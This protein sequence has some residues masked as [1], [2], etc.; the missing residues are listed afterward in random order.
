M[1]AAVGNH[2]HSFLTDG[3]TVF[4]NPDVVTD[5]LWVSAFAVKVNKGPDIPVF[6]QPV[7][8]K[9]VHGGIKAHVPDAQGRHILFQFVKGSEKTDRI[10]P[11]CTGKTQEQREVGLK[12]A[13]VTGELEEGIAEVILIKV[14][15]PAP[16]SIGVGEVPQVFGSVLPMV[17]VWA[18]VGMHGGTVAG[19]GK[20][21]FRDKTAFHGRDNSHAV[22]E[23]LEMLFKVKRDIFSVQYTSG[24]LL[25]NFRF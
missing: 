14:A 1:V 4:V 17:P 20:L 23:L 24:D 8:G 25:C 9:V 15:V 18:G 21:F 5:C 2:G 16:G 19:D 10:M 22:K 3:S 7:S 12:F 6:E 13:V 11:F